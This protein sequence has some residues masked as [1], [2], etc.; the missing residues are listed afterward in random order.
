MPNNPSLIINNWQRGCG[1]SEHLGFGLIRN[2]DIEEFP[3]ALK[4]GRKMSSLFHNSYSSAFTADA[5]TDICT[6]N[7][8]VP[9][10]GTAVQLT[11]TGTLPGGLSTGTNYFII[12]LSSTTFKL[13]T[14]IANAVAGTPINITNAGSG[15][16]TVSTVDPGEVR[17]FVRDESAGVFCV[18]D[19]GLVWFLE[20]KFLLLNGNTSVSKGQGLA[21]FKNSDASATYLFTFG[22]AN[23]DVVEVTSVSDRRNPS[24]NN[25]WQAMAVSSNNSHH[26]IVGQDRIIYFCN[27]YLIGSIKESGIFDPTNGA[28]YT[29]NNQA[30]D[31]PRGERAE[32]LEELGID[33]LIAGANTNKIY[34][35]DRLSDTFRDPLKCPE[36]NIYR[37]KNLGSVV[38][39]LAG[40]K[41]NIYTTQ[42]TYVKPFVTLP[43]SLVNNTGSLV[44]T[45]INWGGIE[46]NY[47]SLIVGISCQSTGNNGIYRIFQ[48]GRIII[49]NIPSIGSSKVTALL[50]KESLNTY[51]AGYDGGADA[52]DFSRRDSYDCIAQSQL[53]RVGTK[54]NPA[55]YSELDIQLA[56]SVSSGKIR[57][58]YRPDTDSA[59]SAMPGGEAEVTS[60][61]NNTSFKFDIGLRDIE[62][63]Q[64]QVELQ[65][66]VELLEIRIIP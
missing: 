42:G 14:T 65:Q 26:A 11:T 23:I 18:D 63:L 13:A 6:S 21:I 54:S 10:T 52:Q 39:V 45:I 37:L 36:A 29:Y 48:D 53:F 49:D 66:D 46:S 55:G 58:R 16:H 4:A 12:K 50:T 20:A 34:P 61:G 35:W 56:K 40:Q 31:L 24:W 28:T 8:T 17:H 51:Y 62:N 44:S 60:L 22:Q 25:A 9:D 38:Y 59:F 64:I 2:C 43:F 1:L 57:I 3:G 30:L 27:E 7:A 32:W 47:G 15:T 41:G 5:G 19:N 33:L